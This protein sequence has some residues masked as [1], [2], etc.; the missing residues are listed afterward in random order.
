MKSK[1]WFWICVSGIIFFSV[2]GL[3]SYFSEIT[4]ISS[5]GRKYIPMAPLTATCFLMLSFVLILL[6]I[7]NITHLRLSLAYFIS[8]IILITNAILITDF[9]FN[10][11]INLEDILFPV[12]IANTGIPVF[13]ISQATSFVFIL[14][15]IDLTILASQKVYFQKSKSV[16]YIGGYLSLLILLVSYVFSIGY[17]YGRP[18]LYSTGRIIPMA[19]STSLSFMLYVVAVFILK[20]DYFPLK[21][22]QLS[23][24]HSIL[25]RFI[26]P[27]SIIPIILIQLSMFFSIKDIDKSSVIITTTI[28]I[29]I[30]LTVGFLA[31][32]ISRY[33]GKIIDQQKATIDDSE[34]VIK[35]GEKKY[36]DLFRTMVQGVVYQDHEGRII[37]V[38]P[39][40]EKLLGLTFEQMQGRTSVDSWGK[41][42]DME[43]NELPGDRHPAMLA[44]E[45][46]T[47]VKNF[48]MGVY[49]PKLDQQVWIIV[50]SIPIFREGEVKPWQVFSTFLDI[51][52][53][54]KLNDEKQRLKEGFE[55]QVI[56]KTKELNKQIGEL[57]HFFQVTVERELR[58]EELRKE[59]ELLKKQ[60]N[61]E[62]NTQR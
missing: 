14:S 49:N 3:I 28:N 53:L 33:L 41:A 62:G 22:L 16:E 26:L 57:E 10:G 15:A 21:F 24:T 54:K 43:G 32:F 61:N 50:N 31:A 6:N 36:L 48:I 59:I 30:A 20:R 44:L 56:D 46:G 37:E 2:L 18:V 27:L 40:A 55:Q 25:L 34:K 38:N 42:T 19:V 17:L 13:R 1:I 58:M 8:A 29:L 5:L 7:N 4:L 52:D 12:N 9:L 47:E 39:A 35:M 51:S 23:S 60:I 11:N 45:A